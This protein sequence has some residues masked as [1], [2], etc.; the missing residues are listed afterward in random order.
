MAAI[1]FGMRYANSANHVCKPTHVCN[2][3]VS[4][5][6]MANIFFLLQA[7]AEGIFQNHTF[8][9]FFWDFLEVANV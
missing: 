6:N 7:L 1:F 4:K 2:F 8:H 3:Y 9:A 5:I